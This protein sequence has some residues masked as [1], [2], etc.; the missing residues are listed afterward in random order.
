MGHIENVKSWYS[1]DPYSE[2]GD[3]RENIIIITEVLLKEQGV[4][5]SHWD[6][7]APKLMGHCENQTHEHLALK[8]SRD[9]FQ[10]SQWSL[11][12]RLHS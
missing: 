8:V 4:W 9:Y 3:L 10:E 2:V 6:H 7:W 11:G 12:N 1:Q 5:P